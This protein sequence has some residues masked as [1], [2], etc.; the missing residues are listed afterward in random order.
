MIEMS[1]WKSPIERLEEL[2]KTLKRKK[3]FQGLRAAVSEVLKAKPADMREFSHNINNHRWKGVVY[4]KRNLLM[5][6]IISIWD[7]KQKLIIRGFPKVKYALDSRVVNK[8]VVCQEKI[9]GTNICLFKLPDNTVVLKTRMT[10]MANNN[11]AWKN[12]NETWQTLLL[13]VNDGRTYR[14]IVRLLDDKN[15]QVFGELY[16]TLNPTEFI[17]YSIPIAF[18]VFDMVDRDTLRF[19]PPQKTMDTAFYYGIPRVRTLWS[20]RL[21]P[22][23]VERIE[24]LLENEVRPDGMEGWMAKAWMEK[25]RDLYMCKLK[26]KTIKEK[27]WEA[28]SS[29]TIPRSIIKKAIRKTIES[30]PNLKTIETILPFVIEELREDVEEEL[31]KRSVDKIKT[32]IRQYLTPSSEEL[33]KLV[34]EKLIELK[35]DGFDINDKGRALR[36]L[37]KALGDISGTALFRMYQQALREIT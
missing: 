20:G 21:T 2:R 33:Y 9:D 22:K 29:V 34:K 6:T 4:Q 13:K 26:C 19:L 32:E 30:F 1:E 28:T 8:H 18:K 10:A 27:C 16:G 24:R 15:Y 11:F 35:K 3:S 23:E 14:R 37:A 7:N 25:D 31:I 17:R 36:A 12:K 5:G